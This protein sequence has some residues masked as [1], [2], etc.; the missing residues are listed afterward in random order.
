MGGGV[1]CGGRTSWPRTG[2][3]VTGSTLIWASWSK[4]VLRVL[5]WPTFPIAYRNSSTFSPS[6]ARLRPAPRGDGE[7]E[8]AIFFFFWHSVW[9]P[10]VGG[11]AHLTKLH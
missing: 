6:R 8:L 4:T 9:L 2:L 1:G 3:R 5:M 11:L 10:L 7:L